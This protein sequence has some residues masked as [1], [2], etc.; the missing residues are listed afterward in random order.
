MVAA[1]RDGSGTIPFAY[2][3]DDGQ[4]PID[5]CT[6]SIAQDGHAPA[7][8]AVDRDRLRV[9]GAGG[10]R[11]LEFRC[12]DYPPDEPASIDLFPTTISVVFTAYT[13][14]RQL[15]KEL[16]RDESKMV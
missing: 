2:F 9:G 10:M 5:D 11:R 13:R 15:D 3:L 1:P 14:P 16:K 7:R 12:G 6:F 8:V 4:M